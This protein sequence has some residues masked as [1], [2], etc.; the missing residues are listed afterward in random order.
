M[1][2]CGIE[3]CV[4]HGLAISAMQTRVPSSASDLLIFP[5]MEGHLVCD[6]LH[7]SAHGRIDTVLMGKTKEPDWE[8][9]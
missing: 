6:C 5:K 9:A 4:A 2:R 1:V 3:L 8:C 7:I